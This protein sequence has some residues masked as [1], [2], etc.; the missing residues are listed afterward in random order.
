MASLSRYP[1]NHEVITDQVLAARAARAQAHERNLE[2]E[3]DEFFQRLNPTASDEKS[4]RGVNSSVVA[5][6]TSLYGLEF[7]DL[8]VPSPRPPSSIRHQPHS[9]S[10][11]RS[12]SSTTAPRPTVAKEKQPALPS[13]RVQEHKE[14]SSQQQGAKPNNTSQ[15]KANLAPFSSAKPP[16][17]RQQPSGAAPEPRS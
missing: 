13:S 7:M 12:S 3:R 15:R 10:I 17:A 8:S 1:I 4:D 11:V 2:R 14:P 5:T 16:A 9:L 6:K